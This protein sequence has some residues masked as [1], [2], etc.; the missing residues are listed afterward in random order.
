MGLTHVIKYR[1]GVSPRRTGCPGGGTEKGLE[2]SGEGRDRP[3]VSQGKSQ[4]GLKGPGQGIAILDGCSH[5]N[6]VSCG[7]LIL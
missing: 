2:E 3:H 7:I 5:N 6:Q 4:E 1:G